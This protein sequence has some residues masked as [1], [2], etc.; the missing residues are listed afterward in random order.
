MIIRDLSGMTSG[1]YLTLVTKQVHKNKL[2]NFP[3]K[4]VA[5]FNGDKDDACGVVSLANA[6]PFLLEGAYF[7]TWDKNNKF[8]GKSSGGLTV[9]GYLNGEV[10]SS[11]TFSLTPTFVWRDSNFGPVDLIEFKTKEHDDKHW[12]LMDNVQVSAVLLQRR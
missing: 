9:T 1:Q 5:A 7:S 10:V 4:P 6:T 2:I 12:W 3:S 11:T 8:Y